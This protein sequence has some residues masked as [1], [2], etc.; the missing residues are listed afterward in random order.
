[1]AFLVTTT[2]PGRATKFQGFPFRNEALDAFT[3]E[4]ARHG[5]THEIPVAPRTKQAGRERM[6]ADFSRTTTITL[7]RID[8]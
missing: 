6:A 1:M 8:G 2:Q 3:A 4:L 7:D 5:T